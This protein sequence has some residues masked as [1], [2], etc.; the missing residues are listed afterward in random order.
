MVSSLAAHAGLHVL[1]PLV[2]TLHRLQFRFLQ[3]S[4]HSLVSFSAITTTHGT[5]DTSRSAK[6]GFPSSPPGPD[7][8]P[9]RTRFSLAITSVWRRF[10]VVV[11]PLQ[12]ACFYT[13]TLDL[14]PMS[15]FSTCS[16]PSVFFALH[17]SVK[18]Y[19]TTRLWTLY[20]RTVVE[21]LTNV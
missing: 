18:D 3:H 20:S 16:I 6:S 1:V 19:V 15:L 14:T 17:C 2:G 11:E 8:N 12:P 10:F 13:V 9:I 5:E 7:A 21:L 4:Y